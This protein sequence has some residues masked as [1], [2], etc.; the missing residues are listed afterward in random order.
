MPVISVSDLERLIMAS[1]FQK[2]PFNATRQQ[3]RRLPVVAALALDW[4]MCNKLSMTV[5]VAEARARFSELI[6]LAES[7]EVV[8][9]TR[10][11]GQ[12]TVKLVAANPTGP[13][14]LPKGCV[15]GTDWAELDRPL[16]EWQ[17]ER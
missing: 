1:T 7:G 11:N 8:E 13:V 4:I 16:D 6:R 12:P 2:A 9:I 17:E 10:Y 15:P 3:P 5:S 14:P